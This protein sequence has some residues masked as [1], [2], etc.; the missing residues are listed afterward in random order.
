MPEIIGLVGFARTGKDTAAQTLI[1]DFGFERLS[2]ADPIRN[3]IYTLNPYVTEAGLR[4][5]NLVDML[6]WDA[7]KTQYLEVRRLL[8]VFGTEVAREQWSDSFWV[9]LGFSQMKP[10]GKYVITDVRF[11]NEAEAVK[12]HG[13]RLWKIIRPGVGP[14]NGHASDSFIDQIECDTLIR[15]DGFL[16]DLHS[17][18]AWAASLTPRGIGV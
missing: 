1:D 18:V 3:A 9:D 10:D 17:E 13:G 2:F 5:Q 16:E 6:G 14:V 7:C 15:N 11:P 4:L 12:A 8:Q